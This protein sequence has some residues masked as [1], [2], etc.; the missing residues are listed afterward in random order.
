MNLQTF[1]L[2]FAQLERALL[3]TRSNKYSD[4]VKKEFHDQILDLVDQIKLKSQ[5]RFT[6]D[7]IEAHRFILK[8]VFNWVEF[9]DNSTINLVPYEIIN[10][11]NVVLKDWISD[12]EDHSI[13]TSLSNKM[14][15][16]SLQ[17]SLKNINDYF[18][19]QVFAR[20]GIVFNKSLIQLNIPKYLVHDYLGNVVL[21]HEIG[22]FIDKQYY[23]ITQRIV[24]REPQFS[25]LPDIEKKK[26]EMYLGE[27]FADVFAAQYIGLSA[28]HYLNYI[29]YKAPSSDSHPST[30]NRINF[31]K[32]FVAGKKSENLDLLMNATK[33]ITDQDLKI[34]YKKI[35]LKDFNNLIPPNIK[36]DSELHSL[37]IQGW[38]IWL[39]KNSVLRKKF[40]NP[41]QLNTI[42]NN[43][44][45]KSISNYFLL[46]EWKK[47]NV[48]NKK[49]NK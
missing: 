37:F 35:P 17:F 41:S 12:Y 2:R 11:L 47:K 30:E 4:K 40:S 26:L 8:V 31:V 23:K 22:H 43:L 48:P 21:Y 5:K 39:N 15:S 24:Q 1:E 18:A 27:H 29:A 20:Y 49:R 7:D 44:I 25:G 16:Y 3:K 32:D 10:C 6:K 46:K 45:E 38:S 36:N 9:L 13:V 28:N 33:I 14:D 42:L 34:R 19:T